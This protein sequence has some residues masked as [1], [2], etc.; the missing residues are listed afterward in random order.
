MG[1]KL[2]HD[3]EAPFPE[4][5]VEPF[6]NVL[7]RPGELVCD[8]F[9]GTGTTAAVA[10]RLGRRFVGFDFRESQVER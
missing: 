10:A 2:A 7:T 9:L 4:G 3:G 1:S 5:L 6:I 8:P